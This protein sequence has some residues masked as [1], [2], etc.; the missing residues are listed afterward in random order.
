MLEY[1]GCYHMVRR[2]L[3]QCGVLWFCARVLWQCFWVLTMCVGVCI[4]KIVPESYALCESNVTLSKRV[5][6]ERVTVVN[7]CCKAVTQW[8]WENAVLEYSFTGRVCFDHWWVCGHSV[9]ILWFLYNTFTSWTLV[10]RNCL[11]VLWQVRDSWESVGKCFDSIHECI[12]SVYE[13]YNNLHE[14]CNTVHKCCDTVLE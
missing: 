2:L 3:S 6:T 11:N 7:Q 1:W 12:D 14:P 5:D 10:L 13:D 8:G 9:W 4:Y